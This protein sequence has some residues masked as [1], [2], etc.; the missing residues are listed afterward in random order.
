MTVRDI[1]KACHVGSGSISRFCKDIGLQDFIELKEMLNTAQFRF[2]S[3]AFSQSTDLRIKEY[4]SR[5]SQSIEMVTKTLSRTRL[6]TL[7]RDLKSYENIAV[8]GRLKAE[9]VAINLQAD[10]MMMGRQVY[11]HISYAEQIE[12]IRQAGKKD[13]ILI[14]SHGGY[15]FDYLSE[16]TSWPPNDRPKIWMISNCCT[17]K[18]NYVSKALVFKSLPGH[19][20]HPYQ[21]QYIAGLIAQEYFSLY[22]S[23]SNSE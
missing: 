22:G 6:Q 1:A 7:C 10:L 15:Y 12:Y 4:G 13:L 2:E 19:V 18:Y 5:V 16:R 23:Y 3:A 8:F 20:G 14:F 11:T 9:S 17:N 21:L